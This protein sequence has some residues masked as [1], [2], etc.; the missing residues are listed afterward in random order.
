VTIVDGKAV[1]DPTGAPALQ[2][3]L[4]GETALDSF[5]YTVR[6]EHGATA[7][8]KVF[9][10]VAGRA[11]ASGV[12]NLAPGVTDEDTVLRMAVGSWPLVSVSPTTGLGAAVSIVNGKVNYDPRLAA[13]IQALDAGDAAADL[14][15]VTLRDRTGTLRQGQIAVTVNGR[16]DAPVAIGDIAALPASQVAELDVLANDRDR[17]AAA[18][19]SITGLP[20]TSAGG[21]LLSVAHGKVVY[22]PTAVAA[23]QA[24]PLGA[25]VA[26]SF[27]Y[28]VLDEHGESATATVQV[29]VA[30][31]NNAPV[32][33]ADA[34]AATSRAPIVIS[35]LANDSDVDAGAVLTL[36]EAQTA[37]RF[38][39]AVAINPDGT[40]TYDPTASATLAALAPGAVRTDRFTYTITD[41]QGLRR[42]AW[43]TVTV[44]GVA[45]APA[46]AALPPAGMQ[47]ARM[48]T[49][50]E[51]EDAFVVDL[52]A[53]FAGFEAPVQTAAGVS[54]WQ[55]GFVAEGADPADPNRGIEIVIGQVA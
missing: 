18:V 30:G 39:A 14:V 31:R 27:S 8:A 6:D 40:L 48:A 51:E 3:L 45:P 26:D 55:V 52:A 21:A 53:E 33:A 28:T 22:D 9:V 41:E 43:V 34:A 13:A 15:T 5:D 19:L 49:P 32:A 4:F 35:V 44:T 1:C 46:A 17:D 37:S 50:P 20:A 36:L 12:L 47:A 7:T 16:N 11:D 10:A 23:F 25:T 38:G 24:L 29:V 42:S 54:S 2:A